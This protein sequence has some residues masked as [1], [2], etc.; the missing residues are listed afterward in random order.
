M[1]SKPSYALSSELCECGS[2]VELNFA[3]SESMIVCG[4]GWSH[5]HLT[6]DI[7]GK[8]SYVPIA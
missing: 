2:G 3:Y 5:S 1:V 7:Q 8:I 6:T 4:N